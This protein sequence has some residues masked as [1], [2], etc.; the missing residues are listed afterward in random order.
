MALAL[1]WLLA[2]G[3]TS[4]STACWLEIQYWYRLEGVLPVFVRLRV[5]IRL[6]SVTTHRIRR[7]CRLK[8]FRHT[9]FCGRLPVRVLMNYCTTNVVTLENNI[10]LHAPSFCKQ[11]L[12]IESSNTEI[13]WPFVQKS[14]ITRL[15]LFSFF[16]FSVV[17]DDSTK[18]PLLGKF[19]QSPF[20]TPLSISRAFPSFLFLFFLLSSLS[21]LKRAQI[22]IVRLSAL[23]RNILIATL[24]PRAHRCNRRPFSY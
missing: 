23:G 3:G 10:S 7:S 14:A 15:W 13:I 4:T 19:Y 2:L 9:L 24:F 1:A 16:F 6:H 18:N 22:G 5:L 21:Q 17:I 20:S 8:G 12:A 11:K